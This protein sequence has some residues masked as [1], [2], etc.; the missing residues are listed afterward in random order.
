MFSRRSLCNCQCNLNAFQCTGAFLPLLSRKCRFHLAR[1]AFDAFCLV[2]ELLHG[3][4]AIDVCMCARAR[5]RTVRPVL[6]RRRRARH[7][8]KTQPGSSCLHFVLSRYGVRPRRTNTEKWR[9]Y[10]NYLKSKRLYVSFPSHYDESAASVVVHA[11]AHLSLPNQLRRPMYGC[12]G[13]TLRETHAFPL[14]KTIQIAALSRARLANTILG[15]T[16][17]AHLSPRDQSNVYR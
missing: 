6:Q 13:R 7:R 16:T 17:R 2:S 1:E 5:A 3:Q 11:P 14:D 9:G 10:K 12:R 15:K 4:S 8:D